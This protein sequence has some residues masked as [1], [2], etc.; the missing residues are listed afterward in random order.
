MINFFQEGDIGHKLRDLLLIIFCL[1]A[2][3]L[4]WSVTGGIEIGNKN[5]RMAF[6]IASLFFLFIFSICSFELGS[7]SQTFDE[8]VYS[9]CL[10]I[11]GLSVIIATIMHDTNVIVA[12]STLLLVIISAFTVKK[13]TDVSLKQIKLQTDPL[14]SLSIKENDALVQVIDLTIENVGNGPA[15]NIQ[16]DIKPHGFTTLSGDPLEK[17]YFFQRGIPLI[18]SKQ[19]YV[20]NLVNFAD[21]ITDIRK[22]Y[23]F[24]MD[25]ALLSPSEAQRFRRIVRS[26]SELQIIVF[27]EN[28]DN[29]KTYSVFNF[30]LC[31]FWGLRFIK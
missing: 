4:M 13:T 19:K 17:L 29:E 27:Y 20:I 5:I 2:F 25:D 12:S 1:T 14:I 26:E 11:F 16:F 9:G 30:N 23:G 31:V 3:V 10:V 28:N 6:L 24:P 8:A 18:P 7:L 15:K 21:K 22:K